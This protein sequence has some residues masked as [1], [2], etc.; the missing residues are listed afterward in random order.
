LS[1]FF[2]DAVRVASARLVPQLL[3]SIKKAHGPGSAQLVEVWQLTLAKILDVL[4][5][6]PAVDT[7][8]E[9]Y[10]CFYESVEVIGQNCLPAEAMS[11]FINAADG[12]L[13]EYQQ[14]VQVRLEEAQKPEEEREDNEDALYAIE[15]DQTLLSDMNKSFHT[16]FKH[17]GISFLQHW[18]RLLPFYDAFITSPDPT[19]RQWA[20]CIMDDVL[21]FCGPEA[22]KYQN[23]FVQ[24]LINGLSDPIAANRQA[25][26]YGVGIAAKNGGPMFSEFVAATIP[27]LFEVTRHPQ[28]RQED[29][30]FAT[31]NACASIAKVLHFNS[32]KVGDVQA[33]VQAWVGTL[34]VVNDDEAA[35][36]AY[37][38]LVQLIEGKNAAVL[39]N[40]PQIFDYVVRALDAETI[41]GQTAE[42]VVTA[43]K[44]LLAMAGGSAAQVLASMPV[45][46]HNAARRW[47]S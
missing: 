41:Q 29:H 30:V 46:R 25:A 16:I 7:L 39:G 22:W 11:T 13:R 15:D 36:Y 20:L 37:S 28:G 2:N 4:A 24:P 26:A 10:Q 44:S 43:T 12:A 1:F 9:L 35:P 5:T 17:Q 14:R 3:N 34:P 45:E 18:E 31:E 19:Q 38:F 6:E 21:E 8:A 42:R 40:V 33:V 47:F 23:H 32:S 27:K